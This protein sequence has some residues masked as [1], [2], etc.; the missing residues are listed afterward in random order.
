[1]VSFSPY[2]EKS[3]EDVDLIVPEPY[4]ELYMKYL[5]MK[6]D[7]Y[8]SDISRYNNSLLLFSTA[9][10]DFQNYYNSQ[11]LPVKNVEFFNA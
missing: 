11:N 3:Q 4:S 8:F 2:T 6:K 10:A 7:L 5:T 9:Y 1:K